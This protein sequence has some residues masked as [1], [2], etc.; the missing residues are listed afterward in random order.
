MQSSNP[1]LYN[2]FLCAKL[3]QL[4]FTFELFV[5][6][7]N[8]LFVSKEYKNYSRSNL[9]RKQLY[10]LFSIFFQLLLIGISIFQF[11]PLFERGIL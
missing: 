1:Y 6:F 2:S 10:Y 7:L 9:A 8:F 5:F 3:E 4:V 11:L